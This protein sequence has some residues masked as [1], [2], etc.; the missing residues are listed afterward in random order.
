MKSKDC[1]NWQEFMLPDALMGG[2]LSK[3]QRFFL[4]NMIVIIFKR[5]SKTHLSI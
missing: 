2:D 3:L 5:G 4:Q 1:N